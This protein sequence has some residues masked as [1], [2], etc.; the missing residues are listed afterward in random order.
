MIVNASVDLTTLVCLNTNESADEPYLWTFFL[1]LDG[2]TVRQVGMGFVGSVQV[3]TAGG[4]HGN[5]NVA[6]IGANRRIDIPNAIGDHTTTL[7]PIEVAIPGQ[8]P[9]RIPGQYVAVAVL[10]EED[11]SDSDGIENGHQAVRQ[12]IELEANDFISGL[13]GLELRAAAQERVNTL[14]GDLNGHIQAIVLECFT[15]LTDTVRSKAKSAVELEILAEHTPGFFW[16]LFD[17]DEI[18]DVRTLRFDERD[19]ITGTNGASRV[20]VEEMTE[21]D[22]D[23]VESVYSLIGTVSSSFKT[24]SGDLTHSGAQLSSTVAETVEHVFANSHLCVEAGRTTTW[25]RHDQIEEHTF[26]FRYPFLPLIWSIEGKDLIG[27]AGEVRLQKSCSL[28]Y[29]HPEG[30]E[31]PAYRHEQREVVISFT[32]I[33]ENGLP[34]IRL[35]NRPEDG[36]YYATLTVDALANGLNRVHLTTD[37]LGFDGQAITS[38]FYAEMA[39]CVKRFAEPSKKYAESK[40]R[41]PRDLWGPS[42][43]QRW[44]VE[45][46]QYAQQ[47]VE[48]GQISQRRL[49]AIQHVAKKRLGLG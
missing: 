4:S 8:A 30:R 32:K 39:E 19:L 18:I 12:L 44:F 17:Q 14:G 34:G 11:N 2:D 24:V 1:K 7:R 27:D 49:D 47:L 9:L 15:Q 37:D 42:A 28:P 36:T 46:V 33:F 26:L 3:H 13:D 20:I 41:G 23:T 6:D 22:D 5:L 35:R 38:P 43:R 16:E 29:F 45:Q 10:L 40:E 25:Q 21:R 31:R 48:A